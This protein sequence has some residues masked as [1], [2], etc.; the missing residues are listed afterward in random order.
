[1]DSERQQKTREIENRIKEIE[2]SFVRTAK[3]G[4][5]TSKLSEG[6]LGLWDLFSSKTKITSIVGI[7]L[8]LIIC[9]KLISNTDLSKGYENSLNDSIIA[10]ISEKN[11]ATENP[12]VSLQAVLK[13]IEKIYLMQ[14]ND[15]NISKKLAKK[16][17]TLIF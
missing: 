13:N 7:V 1:M 5:R 11:I 15:W 12:A 16:L 6:F 2:K 9:G 10:N 4:N 14:L 8:I 17:S 3:V